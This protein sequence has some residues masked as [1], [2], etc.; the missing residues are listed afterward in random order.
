MQSKSIYYIVFTY[1]LINSDFSDS[2]SSFKYNVIIF[3][4][5]TS[6]NLH[7]ASK[8]TLFAEFFSIK[9]N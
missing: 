9:L 4:H 5:F 8:N 7:K 1:I 3:S 6:F 2:V